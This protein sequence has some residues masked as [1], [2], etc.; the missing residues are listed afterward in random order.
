MCQ[1]CPTLFVLGLWFVDSHFAIL[2]YN[3]FF[4]TFDSEGDTHNDE[5]DTHI[6]EIDEHVHFIDRGSIS[7]DVIEFYSNP[8]LS[9]GFSLSLS[10]SS[11]LSLFL[12]LFLSHFLP[13]PLHRSAAHHCKYGRKRKRGR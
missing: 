13:P 6:A 1:A 9:R 11:P 7:Y 10:L 8:S 2:Y 12:F 4:D 5:I 3:T